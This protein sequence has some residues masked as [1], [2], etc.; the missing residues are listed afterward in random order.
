MT[1][2][3]VG[4]ED[5][6]DYHHVFIKGARFV[7]FLLLLLLPERSR[8]RVAPPSIS[9]YKD[10][11]KRLS[12]SF[13]FK[14]LGFEELAK[15][16]R[17]HSHIYQASSSVFDQRVGLGTNHLWF[18]QNFL[19]G[20]GVFINWS[21]EDYAMTVRTL[22]NNEYGGR[23]RRRRPSAS[24]SSASSRISPTNTNSYSSV[25]RPVPSRIWAFRVPTP[26]ISPY[27]HFP[28]A[29]VKV[30][31]SKGVRFRSVSESCER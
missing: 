13:G 1:S 12:S 31:E 8:T 28:K 14:K 20:K 25:F 18:S 9:S 24:L 7:F 27:K 19:F 10:V 5:D 2:M 4:T 11:P 3:V 16:A 23:Q 15:T 30:I 6:D 29:A 22:N 21:F 17:G 26:S